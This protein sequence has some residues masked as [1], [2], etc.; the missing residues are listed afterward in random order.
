MIFATVGTQ[1]PFDR[2]ICAI[3][4]WAVKR[5]RDDVFAQIGPSTYKPLRLR[6][7]QSIDP[8]EFRNK[9]NEAHVVVAH[10]GMGSIITAMEL[11]KP[12]LV[13]PRRA[14]LREHRNDHQLATARHFLA[15]GR[16]SVAFDEQE[17]I[18]KLDQLDRL[19]TADRLS[20]Q[21]SPQLID[22]LRTF[23]ERGALPGQSQPAFS[24]RMKPKQFSMPH[25]AAQ[26]WTSMG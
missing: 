4:S 11:G 12:I 15:Q 18:E 24:D 6:A 26:A 17:M 9:V 16:I 21:A 22:A 10:A 23:I 2:M 25:A 1:V 5:C 14:D 19:S 8:A 7:V 13:M 3:D 20:P